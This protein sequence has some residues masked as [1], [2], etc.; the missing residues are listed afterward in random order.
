MIQLGDEGCHIFC[1]AH[2]NGKKANVLIDTGASKTVLSLEFA[3]K[4]KKLKYLDLAEDNQTSGIGPEKVEAQFARLKSLK[5]KKLD[6][7][8]LIVGTIDVSHVKQLY[9]QLDIAPFDMILG[10]EVLEK[11]N[12][13][14][15]YKKKLLHLG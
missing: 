15:D 7:K 9:Q 2:V 6:I 12:G 5:L 1:K 3:S 11:Y 13:I 8:K 4:L 14:I 10:G